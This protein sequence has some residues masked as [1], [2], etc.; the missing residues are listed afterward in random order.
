MPTCSVC[1]N[2]IEKLPAWLNGVNVKF[3][4]SSGKCGETANAYMF[5]ASA[6]EEETKAPALEVEEDASLEEE[7]EAEL[8]EAEDEV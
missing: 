2:D 1:G 7:I 8:D 3:R 6:D 4:C 5:A